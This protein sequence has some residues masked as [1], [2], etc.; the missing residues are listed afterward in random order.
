MITL[1]MAAPKIT[2]TRRSVDPGCVLALQQQLQEHHQL[3]T[4]FTHSYNQGACIQART[5]V[6]KMHVHVQR[7]RSWQLAVLE[8]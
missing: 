6:C 1:Q 8:A 7:I 2:V 5:C 4:A 3:V